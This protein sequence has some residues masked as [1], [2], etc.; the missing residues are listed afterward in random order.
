[1]EPTLSQARAFRAAH[2]DLP[3]A[4]GVP[5]QLANEAYVAALARVVYYWGYPAVDV[6]GRTTMWQ[7]MRRGP[8]TL[9]GML[10]AAPMNTIGYL[11]DHMSPAQR[12]VVS[13]SND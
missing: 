5:A 10:P 3:R 6:L 4:A 8:G 9:L 12:W 1:M 2:V 11:A 7:V 13:P